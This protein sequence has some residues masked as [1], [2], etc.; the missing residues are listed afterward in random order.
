MKGFVL[1]LCVGLFTVS[2]LYGQL[3]FCTG[4][5]G[6]PVFNEDFGTGLSNG[7]ALPAGLTTYSYVNGTPPDSSFTI[8]S[9]LFY[10]DWHNTD[11]IGA[12]SAPI[13]ENYGL[14]FQ[15][16]PGQIFR[17]HFTLKR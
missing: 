4:S 12:M 3:G 17:G 2:Q 10:F 13:W 7:P 14:V 11:D 1:L 8:S 9:F 5:V 6:D 16:L 15:S